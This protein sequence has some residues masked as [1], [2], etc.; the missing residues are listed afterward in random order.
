MS[1][2]TMAILDDYTMIITTDDGQ[3]II[4]EVLLT[5]KSEVTHKN[6]IVYTNGSRDDYGNVLISASSFN[7]ENGELSDIETEE[8]WNIVAAVY[9]DVEEQAR[10]RAGAQDD[11]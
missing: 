5:F 4:C 6:Y 3:K 9:Q 1:K 11:E 8:E 10:K 2:A 7:P